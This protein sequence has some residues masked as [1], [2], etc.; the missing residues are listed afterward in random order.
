MAY[1]DRPN[2][3]ETPCPVV[4]RERVRFERICDVSGG[5][6]IQEVVSF[7]AEILWIRSS[8]TVTLVLDEDGGVVKAGST[9][10]DFY[11]LLTSVQDPLQHDAAGLARKFDVRAD[12]RLSVVVRTTVHDTPVVVD[13]AR[14]EGVTARRKAYL[15][16]PRDWCRAPCQALGEWSAML[17]RNDPARFDV[18]LPFVAKEA[19][20]DV[21]LVD[22]RRGLDIAR[23]AA[24][25]PVLL[26]PFL[27]G[28]EGNEAERAR[29]WLAAVAAEASG[30]TAA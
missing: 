22:T 17:A 26:A 21:V 28:V 25:A 16:I 1:D 8:E 7:E 6:G 9:Y 18:V 14:P 30:A 13:A 3:F 5:L 2:R 4:R 19:H 23:Q 11:G 15:N 20:P 24:E 10:S 12:G 29:K 27:D